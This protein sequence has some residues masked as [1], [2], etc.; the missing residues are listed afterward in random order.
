MAGVESG[1]F[2]PEEIIILVSAWCDRA[3]QCKAVQNL[4]ISVEEEI[5][6]GLVRAVL[7]PVFAQFL[8]LAHSAR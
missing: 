4:N 5:A 8:M 3:V 7:W 1:I 6:R 2:S